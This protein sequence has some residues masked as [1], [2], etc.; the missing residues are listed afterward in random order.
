MVE[1]LS[2]VHQKDASGRGWG[3]NVSHHARKWSIHFHK[4]VA[5]R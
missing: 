2:G 3:L 5:P 1:E 4:L